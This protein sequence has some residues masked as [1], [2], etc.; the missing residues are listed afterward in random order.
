MPLK[1]YQTFKFNKGWG[2]TSE[3]GFISDK[4]LEVPVV[5]VNLDTC[6]S[7][8]GAY[9]DVSIIY[10]YIKSSILCLIVLF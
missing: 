8:G 1:K 9:Q 10:I 4:L 6:R 7:A 3:G 5:V 2:R